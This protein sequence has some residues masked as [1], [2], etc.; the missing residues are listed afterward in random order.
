MLYVPGKRPGAFFIDRHWEAEAIDE[1]LGKQLSPQGG[2]T[3][4]DGELIVP[5]DG[6]PQRSLY[7][8]FDVIFLDGKDVGAETL[9]SKRMDDLKAHLSTLSETP[10]VASFGASRPGESI[11]LVPKQFYEINQIRHVMT[12]MMKSRHGDE[13]V[14]DDG[15]RRSL[16][17]GL[18]FTPATLPYYAYQVYKFKTPSWISIDFKVR[19]ADLRQPQQQR[20]VPLY[21]LVNK[22]DTRFTD[23]DIESLV[24]Q[25]EG[26]D[27]TNTTSGA[28]L[29]EHME[30][31]NVTECIAECDFSLHTGFWTLR[32]IRADKQQPNSLR[33]Y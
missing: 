29:R 3:L 21:L 15:S 31:N 4:L 33:K 27:R 6:V 32:T 25:E 24:K 14:F 9:L 17:D 8:I 16:S 23:L 1:N 18:V 11:A 5:L 19:M 13:Y 2:M 28:L 12:T 10:V 20:S 22:F 26:E 30:A 7:L